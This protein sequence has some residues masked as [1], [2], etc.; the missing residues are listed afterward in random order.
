[1]N[2]FGQVQVQQKRNNISNYQ[3]IGKQ[4]AK[5]SSY[6]VGANIFNQQQQ[7]NQP[8]FSISQNA[9]RQNTNRYNPF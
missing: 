7:N 3:Q 5:K 4:P 8:N 6:Q 1:M 2:M 9:V